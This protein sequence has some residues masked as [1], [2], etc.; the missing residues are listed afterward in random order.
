MKFFR[1]A[2][3]LVTLL[4]SAIAGSPSQAATGTVRILFGSTGIVVG[5][6][7]GKGTLTF[8]GKDYPFAV[9]GASLGAT[10]SESTAVLEGRVQGLNAP[11]DLAGSYIAVGVGAAIVGGGGA[12]RLRNAKGVTLVVRGVRLGAGISFNLARVTITMI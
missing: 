10:L 12:A 3:F 8:Q 6:G 11:E 5:V 4:A 1:A 9:S 2:F 7:G